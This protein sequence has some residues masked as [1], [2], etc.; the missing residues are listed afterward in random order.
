MQITVRA[1]SARKRRLAITAVAALAVAVVA[2]MVA[3]SA[4]AD[5]ANAGDV[6]VSMHLSVFTPSFTIAGM[7]TRGS[8]T[9][10]VSDRGLVSIPQSSLSFQPVDVQVNLPD[11]SDPSSTSPA[12]VSV[13]AV[14][15]SAFSGG[16]DPSNGSAF[17]VGNLELLWSQSPSMNNCPVGPF[18]VVVRS[19]AQGA[20]SY[21]TNTGSVS[22]VD[23]NF[24]INAIPNAT[25]GCGG[26]ESAINNALSLPVTT[27]TTTTQPGQ[28]TP[29]T[30]PTQGPPVPAV[31]LS[32]SFNPAPR[33]SVPLP[34]QHHPNPPTTAGVTPTT[35]T[36]TPTSSVVPPPVRS[37]SEPARRVHKS[38]SHKVGHPSQHHKAQP[39]KK[40][41][42]IT[43]KKKPVKVRATRRGVHKTG[44]Q[45]AAGKKA[46]GKAKA[47]K[48]AKGSR[49]LSFVPA[50]FVKR[51]PSALAT[52][53]N[54]AG[55]LG[56]LVFSSLALWLVTSE[57][58]DFKA[59]ARRQRA[60][61]I[62]GVTDRR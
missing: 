18:R 41:L 24:A 50:S 29:T 5:I 62:A 7:S 40:G 38:V 45:L 58:S 34:I 14:A 10:T 3:P 26:N 2:P 31:V 27:T 47:K 1:S 33:A 36:V 37:G 56:L 53:L 42:H 4:G 52:G 54:L 43:L 13:Q 11:S 39:K 61:R 46:A 8:A 28:P 16:L 20:I 57:L 23:P 60:H 12:V 49:Q 21:S 30:D 51:S 59:G 48:A 9:A 19:N 32:L 35:E 44:A 25:S 15:T 22:M 6:S 55:L 17:L